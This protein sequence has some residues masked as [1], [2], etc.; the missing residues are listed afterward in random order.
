MKSHVYNG[1]NSEQT[2][3]R[4]LKKTQ[5]ELTIFKNS[6]FQMRN[7]IVMKLFKT[8]SKLTL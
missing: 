5:Q 6:T 2:L 4:K 3:E 1:D 7:R 8:D